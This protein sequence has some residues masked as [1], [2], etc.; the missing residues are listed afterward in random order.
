MI[1]QNPWAWLGMI[2]VALPILIH[3]L[4]RGHAR[5]SRFPTLRFIDASRLL[6]TKRSRIQDPLLLAVRIAI[7]ACAALALAQPLV[8]TPGRRQALD[9]GLARAVIMDTSAS[10][11]RGAI[12]SMR[13]LARRVAAE[14]QSSIVVET[15][16]PLGELPAAVAWVARQQR[17][18]EIAIVSDFQ[19][20]QVG[21]ADLTAI[22]AN[23]GIVLRR[24]PVRSSGDSVIVRTTASRGLMTGVAT[25]TQNGV[26]VEWRAGG[27]SAMRVPVELLG[28]AEDSA[29]LAAVQSAAASL[30]V[31][32]PIDTTRSVAIVFPRFVSRDSLT[33]GLVAARA[34]WK[35]ALLSR[36][37]RSGIAI[38]SAGDADVGGRRRL[39]L[40]ANVAP[41][42]LDAARLVSL[43]RQAMS[44]A[45]SAAELE[46]A[47]VSDD[48][49]T[50][51]ER[52]A[53]PVATSTR[54]RPSDE[55]GPSDARWLW[56]VALVLLLVE[57]RLR[58]RAMAAQAAPLERARAA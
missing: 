10:V 17:A 9:R 37:R 3:L 57:W 30:A 33:R 52:P 36:I 44:A 7:V 6:P 25:R 45:P 26:D 48:E 56:V 43:A 14:A 38:S 1:W 13:A 40:V 16:N 49:L 32:M 47:T 55:N 54:F 58:R 2:G 42:S 18:G 41:A 8:L 24:M 27:D 53:A 34:P 31:A 39:M 29:A 22:P 46:P 21:K 51:W 11:R 50:T 28:G 23:V 5:V 15:G 35:L 12:D 19:Q 20:G 4:G